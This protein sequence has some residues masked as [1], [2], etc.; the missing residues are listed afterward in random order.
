MI[1]EKEKQTK[2]NATLL[3]ILLDIQR[4][5]QHGPIASQVDKIIRRKTRVHPIYESMVMKITTLGGAPQRRPDM[6]PRDT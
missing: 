3:Q 2:I 1:K 4:Q 6:E 5:L